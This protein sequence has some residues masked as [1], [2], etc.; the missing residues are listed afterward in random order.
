MGISAATMSVS[1]TILTIFGFFINLIS[2]SCFGLPWLTVIEKSFLA[3]TEVLEKIR[4][5]VT[6]ESGRTTKFGDIG[7]G[8]S[9]G[10][11]QGCAVKEKRLPLKVAIF[12]SQTK[13]ATLL[14]RDGLLRTAALS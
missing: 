12:D 3:F 5:E 4:R 8:P 13:A 2:F 1:V 11:P 10:T 7:V 9:N 14:K 6:R